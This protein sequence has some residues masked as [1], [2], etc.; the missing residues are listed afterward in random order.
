MVRRSFHRS[1][2]KTRRIKDAECLRGCLLIGQSKVYKQDLR[3]T[4][5]GL[6]F[7]FGMRDCSQF[8]CPAYRRGKTNQ[9]MAEQIGGQ[10]RNKKNL[11]F[12][13]GGETIDADEGIKKVDSRAGA[14]AGDGDVW[15]G[16]FSVDYFKNINSD[17][18]ATGSGSY[19]GETFDGLLA[20]EDLQF[21]DY[22]NNII[23]NSTGNEVA[24]TA[25]RRL[26]LQLGCSVGDCSDG[27]G[28]NEDS[29]NRDFGRDTNRLDYFSV[30]AFDVYGDDHLNGV[31]SYGGGGGTR[32]RDVVVD[33]TPVQERGIPTAVA[34]GG[35]KIRRVPIGISANNGSDGGEAVV[36]TLEREM[37][38][39]G[40]GGGRC[41]VVA[42]TRR[43]QER[44][45]AIAGTGGGD[46]S[47]EVP[48]GIL[49]NIGSDGG[50]P[51][52]QRLKQ[53]G[54][55][56]PVQVVVG[57]AAMMM[58]MLTVMVVLVSVMVNM[59]VRR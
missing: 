21:S 1:K 9:L 35:I 26:R 45:S 19:G 28:T 5:Q 16:L 6:C 57:A 48:V 44:A 36:Q 12:G 50:E 43:N 53:E 34:G 33:P 27:L 22:L 42:G 39:S 47:R 40:D 29:E 17:L 7:T 3:H 41:R 25:P 38:S 30:A 46:I 37:G 32:D 4:S 23:Y 58:V 31:G 52:V 8:I 2:R 20:D 10:V 18:S 11:N 49:A 15:G 55:R 13:S 51:I 24:G 56:V 59:E 54:V 14:V